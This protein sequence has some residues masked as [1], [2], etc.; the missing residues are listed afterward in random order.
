V[1]GA[2]EDA[3]S[4]Y[5]YLRED[6]GIP[7]G[8]IVLYG[9][10]VGGGPTLRL[11]TVEPVAGVILEA[12][13]TSAFR[14][15]TGVRLFPFDRYENEERIGAIEA[16]VLLLHGRADRVVPFRHGPA[17]LAAAREPKLHAWFAT[18]GHND[19]PESDRERYD[20]AIRAFAAEL[21]PEPPARRGENEQG[22]P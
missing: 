21:D 19:I 14:V 5:A 12:T 6:L 15:I 9:R 20:A 22:G 11:A 2:A 10:S 4:A 1:E 8:R 18:A 7:A 13:F 3:R 16:P 17:L